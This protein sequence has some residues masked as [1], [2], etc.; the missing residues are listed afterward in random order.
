MTVAFVSYIARC[1]TC[2]HDKTVSHNPAV[3]AH[4]E[5]CPNCRTETLW[6]LMRPAAKGGPSAKQT[7]AK[8]AGRG[9]PITRAIQKLKGNQP[10]PPAE[11]PAPAG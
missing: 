9:G 7:P 6:D 4:V 8:A 10:V 11:P 1:R 2:G 3:A 5:L